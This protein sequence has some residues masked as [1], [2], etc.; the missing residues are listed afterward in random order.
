[1]QKIVPGKSTQKEVEKNLGKASLVEKNKQY[2]ELDD[3]KYALEITYSNDKVKEYSYTYTQKQPDFSSLKIDSKLLTNQ[4]TSRFMKYAD[5][6]G[7]VLV[8]LT[9]KKIY[10]VKVK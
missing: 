10:S 5:K 3:L 6:E 7:E 1:M 2:Y 8:D 9:S 4:S